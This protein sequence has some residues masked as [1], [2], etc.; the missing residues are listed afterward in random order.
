MH[1]SFS[2][3]SLA[4]LS[5]F[6]LAATLGCGAPAESPADSPE[7]PTAQNENAIIGGVADTGDPSIIALYAKEPD[8]MAGALCTATIISPTVVLTA[9]HCVHPDLVGAKAE[10]N[11]LTAPDLTDP[12]KPSPRLKVKEVHWDPLF[13]RLNILDGHDVAVAILESP[14]T[15]TPIAWNKNPLPTDLTGKIVRLVGYGLNDS[16]NKKGAGVKRQLSIKLNSFDDKFVKTGSLIPWKGICQGD[17][18][19]PVLAKIGG[20]ET[21]IG[22]NSFGILLC[23]FEASSTRVDTYKSFVEKYL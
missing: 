19:G 1:L 21:V 14:T 3:S 16:V 12:S 15:L 6:A 2:L 18:G 23:L 9:A 4:R 10:F 13:S 7:D 11:V 8:K 22:V 20:V 17:S 5:L